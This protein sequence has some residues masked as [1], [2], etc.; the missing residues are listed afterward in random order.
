MSN[1]FQGA[2]GGPTLRPLYL[3]SP[4][5]GLSRDAHIRA[6]LD[7][8]LGHCDGGSRCGNRPFTCVVHIKLNILLP[9]PQGPEKPRSL[10]TRYFG[11][12]AFF[13]LGRI[14]RPRR[15]FGLPRRNS[16][17]ASRVGSPLKLGCHHY[18]VV[19]SVGG[20]SL[21]PP[22]PLTQF[23]SPSSPSSRSGAGGEQGDPET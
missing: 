15:A 3:S 2:Q 11:G 14:G 17:F 13:P 1:F 4:L 23:S 10:L 9:L 6:T 20:R 18:F 21:W 8:E 12:S 22:L 16:L 5:S 7:C 19:Q